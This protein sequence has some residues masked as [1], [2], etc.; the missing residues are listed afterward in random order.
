MAREHSV[1]G[2]A[3][4]A[5]RPWDDRGILS[6]ADR[7]YVAARWP[8][9]DAFYD[10]RDDRTRRLVADIRD[11]A[12]RRIE[13]WV[14]P[15]AASNITVQRMTLVA[16]NLTA[17]WAR[18]VRLVCPLGVPLAPEL[19]RLHGETT[20]DQRVLREMTL[21]DPFG[22]WC[23]GAPADVVRSKDENAPLRLFIGPWVAPSSDFVGD[24]S[25]AE[26]VGDDYHIDAAWWTAFAARGSSGTATARPWRTDAPGAVPAAALAGALG[27]ADLFKRAIGHQGT[28]AMPTCAWDVWDHSFTRDAHAWSGAVTRSVPTAVH[29]G[30][31]LLA[32]V[33]AIGSALTYL[34]DLAPM[35]GELTL[36]DRDHVETSNLNRSPLFTVLDVVHSVAKTDVVASYV[37]ERGVRV[38]TLFGTWAELGAAVQ[39]RSFDVWISLTNEDGAWAQVPFQLPPVVLHGT[40][41]SGWGFGAGRHVPRRDDCTLCRMPRP[42][43]AFRGPCAEGEIGQ[44]TELATSAPVRASLPFL[45][46]AAAALVLGERMK[47]DVGSAV[48]GLPNDVAA[49]LS[50]GLPVVQVLRRGPVAGCRGCRAGH[51]DAWLQSNASR[52]R[53][54]P[55]SLGSS[56]DAGHACQVS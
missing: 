14:D 5:S 31:T 8:S 6:A 47:L 48:L 39:A 32:G 49:D 51:T 13:C 53:Y 33:G 54:A 2:L 38:D 4:G 35:D 16:C 41:T 42:H 7:A 34:A 45:S 10:E 46:T 30:R 27:A 21:A 56:T 37:A 9:A 17:R 18:H 15:A 50:A 24:I 25:P 52:G 44:S 20:L 29:W 22:N 19:S 1:D 40:T 12:A 43:A 28:H 23:V 11:Y 36:L 3:S 26:P 55:Y